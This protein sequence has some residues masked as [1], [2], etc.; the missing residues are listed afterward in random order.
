MHIDLT[1]YPRAVAL[2]TKPR[3]PAVSDTAADIGGP[4]TP[5]TTFHNHITKYTKTAFFS[6][7]YNS[8]LQ[9][10]TQMFHAT[11]NVLF[12]CIFG[13]RRFESQ[14]DYWMSVLLRVFLQSFWAN[15]ENLPSIYHKSPFPILS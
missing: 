7:P 2:Y 6:V 9:N 3:G 14:L 15:A 1:V 10:I 13:N 4:G 5:K 12:V 11:G 8:V